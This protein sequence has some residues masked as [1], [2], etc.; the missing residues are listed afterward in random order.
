M[1]AKHS[2][3][4][5]WIRSVLASRRSAWFNAFMFCLMPLF[6]FLSVIIVGLVTL[7]EG[8]KEGLYTLL[9][10]LLAVLAISAYYDQLAFGIE[11]GLISYVSVW[12]LAVLLRET[13]SWPLVINLLCLMAMVLAGIKLII[14]PDFMLLAKRAI[15]KAMDYWTQQGLV[16]LD[17]EQLKANL[18]SFAQYLLGI[19]MLLVMLVSVSN[20]AFA[21]YLQAR[22]YNPGGFAKEWTMFR[23]SKLNLALFAM[24]LLSLASDAPLFKALLIISCVPMVLSG[25]SLVHWRVRRWQLGRLLILIPC[26]VLLIAFMPISFIPLMVIGCVDMWCN[27]RNFH[28]HTNRC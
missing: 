19:Q 6:S 5:N 9:V 23:A 25:L 20:L 13:Q 22:L 11:Q 17:A 14:Q 18:D 21:R 10:A 24:A 8:A 7:R 4:D 15:A 1:A 28:L 12:L 26:Y 27:F 16:D 3:I 2:L